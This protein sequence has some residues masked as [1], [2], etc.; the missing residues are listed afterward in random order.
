MMDERQQI[1][2][3]KETFLRTLKFFHRTCNR[4]K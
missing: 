1:K 4:T 2:F 3:L